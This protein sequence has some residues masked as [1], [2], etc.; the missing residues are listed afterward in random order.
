MKSALRAQGENEGREN[1]N[2]TEGAV[3]HGSVQRVPPKPHAMLPLRSL[4]GARQQQ[5][6]VF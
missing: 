3:M 2:G 1:K 5:V 4:G 6:S